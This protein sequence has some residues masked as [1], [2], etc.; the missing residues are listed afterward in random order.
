MK[1]DH[2]FTLLE[3]LIATTVFSVILLL[4]TFGLVQVGRNYYRG[5][6]ITR[7]QNAARSV[8]S[9]LTQ[10]IQYSGS[11]PV[12]STLPP[13][14]STPATVVPTKG[15]FCIGSLKYDY[16]LKVQVGDTPD[17]YALRTSKIDN[18][19]NCSAATTSPQTE[20]LG[21]NMSLRQFSIVNN[22][23]DYTITLLIAY[24]ENDLLTEDG[25]CKGGAGSQFCASSSLKTTVHRRLN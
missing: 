21:K 5:S 23:P 13:E 14:K 10:S 25:L 4:C 15:S 9:T 16:Q 11:D 20:L 24:G 19:A 3:L 12:A 6:T 17:S 22:G 18:T 1:D 2:G 8:M 7:T